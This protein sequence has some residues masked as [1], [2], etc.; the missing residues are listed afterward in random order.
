MRRY[1][2]GALV[3]LLVFSTAP[4]VAK[5]NEYLLGP[6]DRVAIKIVEWKASQGNYQEWT[7]LGGEYTVGPQGTISVPLIGSVEAE[8][9]TPAQVSEFLAN[10]LQE[11]LAL[12]TKPDASVEIVEYRPIFI[13]GGVD[14]PGPYPF[15]PGLTVLKALSLA[16]GFYRSPDSASGTGRNA[17]QATGDY[18]I[19]RIQAERLLAQ[20]AR[21]KA[22]QAGRDTVETP[23]ELQGLPEADELIRQE[24]EIMQQRRANLK[25]QLAALADLKSLYSQEADSLAQTVVIT[26]KQITIAQNEINAVS[27][28][29]EK[30][31]SVTSRQT[32]V[33]RIEADLQSKRL[34]AQTGEVRARESVSKAEHDTIDATNNFQAQISSDLVA[35]EDNLQQN[36]AKIR[37]S[38]GLLN[39]ATALAPN[40]LLNKTKQ[41][42]QAT[43][44]IVRR[45]NG[46]SVDIAADETASVEPGDV[47]RVALP[48]DDSLGALPGGAAPTTTGGIG[49]T[50]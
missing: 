34:E 33:E 20:R 6:Q 42:E 13:V 5:D 8:G 44:S 23:P 24:V 9:K 1:R 47:V 48:V 38:K 11:K 7:P 31:L 36:Y 40:E 18:E 12:S 43:Y 35:V 37:Q 45:E 14:K 19:S 26:D 3:A 50:P 2:G 16:G 39:E 15:Q 21:L 27:S 28:L 30:G 17:I 41:G 25:S 49:T 22:E 29:V 46:K 4:A 32:S 10:Q